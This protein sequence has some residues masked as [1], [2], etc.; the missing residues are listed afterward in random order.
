MTSL[1]KTATK[2]E[3]LDDDDD[4]YDVF[5]T[6]TRFGGPCEVDEDE[7]IPA[8]QLLSETDESDVEVPASKR[9]RS[10]VVGVLDEPSE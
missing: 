3:Y 4:D 10:S 8:T 9:S 2:R 6:R 1:F 5:I 7:E